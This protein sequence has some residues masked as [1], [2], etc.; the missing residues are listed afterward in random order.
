MSDVHNMI[1]TDCIGYIYLPNQTVLRPVMESAK[2]E[3]GCS[4]TSHFTWQTV[5]L[6]SRNDK[7]DVVKDECKKKSNNYSSNENHSSI[8]V[9]LKSENGGV[10]DENDHVICQHCTPRIDVESTD[11]ESISLLHGMDINAFDGSFRQLNCAACKSNCLHRRS[12]LSLLLSALTGHIRNKDSGVMNSLQYDYQLRMTHKLENNGNRVEMDNFEVFTIDF[13]LL[14]RIKTN[15]TDIFIERAKSDDMI[16]ELLRCD[17]TEFNTFYYDY[18][19]FSS[20]N[21]SSIFPKHMSLNEIYL[22]MKKGHRDEKAGHKNVHCRKRTI[23][24]NHCIFMDIPCHLYSPFLSAVSI[25]R[26]QCVSRYLYY[27]LRQSVPGMKLILVKHQVASLKWMRSRERS[28]ASKRQRDGLPVKIL[29]GQKSGVEY[30]FNGRYLQKYVGGTICNSFEDDIREIG[31]GGI[32]ADEPGLGKTITSLSLVLQTMHA[33]PIR[34][35]MKSLESQE[36]ALNQSIFRSYFNG[37]LPQFSRKQEMVTILNRIRRLDVYAWFYNPV[38]KDTPEYFDII[39]EPICLYDIFK[40][41][42]SCD[43]TFEEFVHQVRLCFR[44]VYILYCF[45]LYHL[46]NMKYLIFI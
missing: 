21:Y 18:K 6:Q 44:L 35:H 45:C 37:T 11:D 42:E 30:T 29:Y 36:N 33:N 16:L 24:D 34:T 2:F 28:S 43:C 32:C 9:I 46:S 17:W 8:P 14:C 31:R 15:S 39:Q 22:Q 12:D 27:S 23:T 41:T 7:S 3:T 38:P 19:A 25:A 13:L 26:L 20:K 10:N 5:Q 1:K 40:K 4:S